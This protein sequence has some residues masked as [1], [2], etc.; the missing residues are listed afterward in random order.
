MLNR[1]KYFFF[2]TLLI[3]LL[4]KQGYAAP[5]P[6]G[7]PNRLA[8]SSSAYLRAAQHQPVDWYE[9]DEEAF[10]KARDLDR[11][12]LLDI[13]AIWCHW[14][15]VMDRETYENPDLA[16]FINQHF[17]AIKVDRDARPDIDR[18]YQRA[19]MALAG[20]AG[21]PLTVFLTPEGEVMFGGTYF[22]PEARSGRPGMR[23]LLSQIATLYRENKTE[24]LQH[25]KDFHQKLSTY[26]REIL[27]PGDLDPK[28][29]LQIL[30]DM[31]YRFEPLH[32][33]FDPGPKFPRP[34]AIE[35][36]L[37]SL[38]QKPHKQI[39]RDMVV[40][41]LR[42]MAKGGIF[43]QL[44][45]GFHRYATD[46]AWRVPHFEKLLD[47]NA[48]L[49]ENYLQ[50]YQA[51]G[52]ALFKEVALATIAYINGTLSNQETGGFYATQDADI[53]LQ[54]DGSYFTWTGQELTEVLTLEEAQVL[55]LYFGVPKKGE[56][57]HVLYVA[58]E[59]EKIAQ[60]LSLPLD[61][62]HQH[63][64]SGLARLKA[65][66]QQRQAPRIDTTI[67]SGWNGLM[68]SAYFEGYRVLQQKELREFALQTLDRV[69]SHL[70][71]P[72][73]GV[74]HALVH[75]QKQELYLFEDQI[76]LT[77]ALLDAFE[78]TGELRYLSQARTLIDITL[79]RFWD[80]QGGG[81]FDIPHQEKGVAL[82]QERSKPIHD[83]SLAAPNAVAAQ[84]LDRLYYLTLDEEY[85]KRA[86]AT[87]KAF[88]GKVGEYGMY[89]AGFALALHYH[90]DH[91]A[92]V[93]IIGQKYDVQTQH[94]LHTAMAT[95]R[96]GK[97]VL[98]YEKQQDTVALPPVVANIV[99][100]TPPEKQPIAYVCAGEVC[101]PP[102]DQ[103]EKVALLLQ[104]IGRSTE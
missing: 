22:P 77:R 2:A 15:H 8:T 39:F 66:R 50:A 56:E 29:I 102:T 32:G 23:E 99:Q 26:Q 45:G 68:I 88:A 38:Y 62:V 57:R 49:L 100:A 18:R 4:L 86:E 63:L 89:G 67:Y 24:L 59:P 13:G 21:W 95:Y 47:L 3:V 58:T 51:T 78:I 17:I 71:T 83:H 25:V 46:A 11:P 101:G 87:L 36:A 76:Y 54:D 31:E 61:T 75:D 34:A 40:T 98:V 48:A 53:H 20:R 52:E 7:K 55:F 85:R 19:V 60:Q 104:T 96:P 80:E 1:P 33:G 82:L 73:Q 14:C 65:A 79:H 37:W 81:F 27:V 43:D 64:R 10:Q 91:P 42:H 12:V 41:T 69:W 94:L 90:L 5:S 35:L 72:D 103:A 93:V 6:E 74:A 16:Q 92:Q 70:F 97:L 28:I 44:G 30:Q 9:W 84:V